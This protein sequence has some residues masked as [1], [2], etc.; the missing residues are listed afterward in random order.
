[1][2][3]ILIFSHEHDPNTQGANPLAASSQSDNQGI[4]KA[5]SPE[6]KTKGQQPPTV[7]VA[8]GPNFRNAFCLAACRFCPWVGVLA[9]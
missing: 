4:E 7:R 6:S 5:Q 9:G 3:V 1:M 8:S 2:H